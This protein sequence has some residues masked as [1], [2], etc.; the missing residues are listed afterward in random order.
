MRPKIIQRLWTTK[1]RPHSSTRIHL[2]ASARCRTDPPLEHSRRR[3]Q[4]QAYPTRL[5]GQDQTAIKEYLAVSDTHPAVIGFLS[6]VAFVRGVTGY[7]FVDR[8]LLL[9]ALYG[10]GGSENPQQRLALLGDILL[11]Y[12][13]K[14]DWFQLGLPAS[15]S[16]RRFKHTHSSLLTVIV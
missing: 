16:S 7:N 11:Q 1:V 4:Y 15:E 2:T 3:N 8:H 10:E 13:L 14:D 5:R 12:V 6:S 9:Q